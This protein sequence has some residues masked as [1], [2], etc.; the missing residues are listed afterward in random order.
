MQRRIKDCL[1]KARCLRDVWYENIEMLEPEIL[2]RQDRSLAQRTP[3]QEWCAARGTQCRNEAPSG[4]AGTASCTHLGL[5][6][7]D[8]HL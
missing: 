3:R 4:N 5:Y 7:L 8:P 2:Q 6:S 1:V